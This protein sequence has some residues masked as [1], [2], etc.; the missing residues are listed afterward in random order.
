MSER[1]PPRILIRLGE[2]QTK[3]PWR[4]VLISLLTLIPAIYAIVG[5]GGLGFRSDFAELLPEHKDSV[6]EMHRVS[7]RLPGAA[8]LTITA[9]I[10]NGS[11]REALKKFVDL[12]V[13]RLL[14]LGPN[15]VGA[16]DYGV[17]ATQE[18]FEKNKLLYAPLKDL[19]QAHDEILERYDYELAKAR[20]D[21]VDEEDAPPELTA[22]AVE[23]R[24]KDHKPAA[25]EGAP[26]YPDGYYMNDEGTFIALLIRTPISGTEAKA[27]FQSEVQQIVESVNP[28]SLDPSMLVGYTGNFVTSA[29]EYNAIVNDL[30][31]VGGWGV[32]GVL[33]SVLVF[34][35]RLRTV[36]AMGATIV[37]SLLWTFGLTRL[38][39]GYLNSATG[40]LVS[41]IAGNGINYGIMYMARYIEARRDDG[42][43]AA[44]AIYLAHR[45]TWLP[46][47]AGSTTAMLAYGTLALTDFR[48][49]K[50]FGVISGYGM[51]LCWIATYTFLPAVLAISERL[52]PSFEQNASR[53][54][55]MRGQYGLPFAALAR[56]APRTVTVIGIVMGVVTLV[57]S[58]LYLAADPME[59]DLAN[60]RNER[61]D[62]TAAGALS[63]RVDRVVGRMGQ[64][65]M[66][67]MTDRVDQVPM[68]TDE[69]NKRHAEAPADLKPFDKVVTIFSLLPQDQSEKIKL[70]EEMRDR[71]QRA[72]DRGFIGDK[73][74]EKIQPHLPTGVLK[75]IGI[76]D[77][78]DQVARPFTER[79]GTRGRIV[80]IVPTT[81]FSMWDAHYLMRW[82]DS[83]RYTKLPT[84]EVIKGSGNAVIFSDMIITVGE[85][86]PQ[87]IFLSSLGSIVVILLAFRFNRQALGVF[88]P[89]LLGISSLF[90]FFYLAD[91]K[92][93]F[94]NFV[95]IPITIG[96]GAEYAHSLMQRYRSEGPERLHTI[97]VETGGALI[98]CSMT[99]LIGYTVLNLSINHGI[100]SFGLA[101]AMGE[102]TCLLSAV[103]FL[104]A[105][106]YWI[107]ARK[108]QRQ[109]R[110]TQTQ[111]VTAAVSPS[112]LDGADRAAVAES[113]AQ[114][115][116]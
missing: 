89:W 8:T 70:I 68:L 19:R 72:R 54:A 46:T 56:F 1:K 111:P 116:S 73:D 20:G 63:V 88:L 26:S 33:T 55:R 66:A 23:E 34:F 95:T 106:L 62:K 41:I 102:L 37:V 45:D 53:L 31:H 3:Y 25:V 108:K 9:E 10:E 113:S 52:L 48:G 77:L 57:C 67:I 94:L 2:L 30:M 17:Q 114:T 92:L 109:Q 11:N 22:E 59:Y 105:A 16:V 60:I 7:E 87:A 47:L 84:G 28:R 50:H 79:D 5:H 96:L 40:F 35:V 64:D 90:T 14:A 58:G 42:A 71:I 83:Y 69:L 104:P 100:R 85:D 81:G 76:E 61:K 29:E 12:M 82:A 101:A 21:F 43:D 4:F 112:A 99:T 97:A 51:I 32:A 80:Y 93:N 107:N 115:L 15:K 24:L 18:F 103:V 44:R 27:A 78:P 49:F 75:P 110:S 98:L 36:V 91:I 13:P 74:W 65:G 6:I 86:A 38:T 39:I